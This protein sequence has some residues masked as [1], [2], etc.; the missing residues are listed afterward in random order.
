ME[1]IWDWLDLNVEVTLHHWGDPISS[2]WFVLSFRKLKILNQRRHKCISGFSPISHTWLILSA[3]WWPAMCDH[4]FWCSPVQKLQLLCYLCI[5][6]TRESE[7]SHS[8]EVNALLPGLLQ[9]FNISLQ[10]TT[11]T[12]A[13]TDDTCS[14]QTQNVTSSWSGS[15][16]GLI[17][18]SVYWVKPLV[19]F[20]LDYFD[21][22][23]KTCPVLCVQS[24]QTLT[25]T[26]LHYVSYN[27][28]TILTHNRSDNFGTSFVIFWKG[29]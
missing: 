13:V 29:M 20:F 28:K 8:W 24:T 10:L 22:L 9:S 19:H 18:Q 25:L 12:I 6:S 7:G 14:I 15:D 11:W 5:R 17:V 4:R 21:I 1:I 16:E 26:M 2:F 3:L 27:K 23:V